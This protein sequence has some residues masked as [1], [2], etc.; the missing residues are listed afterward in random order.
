M[1][2]DTGYLDE[3]LDRP[4]DYRLELIFSLLA[5]R[6]E[7]DPLKAAFRALHT[8]DKMTYALGLEY[9]DSLLPAA[10][11]SKFHGLLGPSAV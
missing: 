5:L 6:H 11:R 1:L 3:S 10:V 9:V 4:V 7:R 2:G 8:K